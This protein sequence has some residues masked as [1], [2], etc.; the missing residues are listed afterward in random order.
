MGRHFSWIA[1]IAH[2]WEEA[3]LP[4]NFQIIDADDQVRLIK[5]ILKNL[6][7]D[8]KSGLLTAAWLL[9]N[10][11]MRVDDVKMLVVMIF[12]ITH[13]RIYKEYEDACS[14]GGLVFC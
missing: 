7:L 2:A 3:G 4:Q 14:R 8:E 5:R 13:K 1:Q 12:Q 9:M 11:K 6:D 10:R